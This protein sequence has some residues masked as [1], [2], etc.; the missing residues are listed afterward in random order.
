MMK[1]TFFKFLIPSVLSIFLYS[2]GGSESPKTE[3]SKANDNEEEVLEVCKYEYNDDT[4][5]K[6]TSFKFTDKVGVGGTLDSFLVKAGEAVEEPYRILNELEFEIYTAS[7]NSNNPDRDKKI[8]SFFFGKMENT[9]VIK[10]KV[11][12]MSGSP[13]EGSLM[14]NLSLNGQSH[15][16][17]MKYFVEGNSVTINGQIDLVNWG[18]QGAVDALNNVCLDLHTGEDGVS[19]LWSAVDIEVVSI[20]KEASKSPCKQL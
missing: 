10:G 12:E 18:A 2:C 9:D 19:K 8:V 7:V 15:S 5:I 14:V 1:K 13:R 20:L 17:Q 16:Q 3:D 6:W 11:M 4:K